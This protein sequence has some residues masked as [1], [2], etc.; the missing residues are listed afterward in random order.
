M[1][2]LSE[3]VTSY[4]SVNLQRTILD[5]ILSAAKNPQLAQPRRILRFAQN[6]KGERLD[7]G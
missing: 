6:D 2:V 4:D 1:G 5:V 7:E 3:K